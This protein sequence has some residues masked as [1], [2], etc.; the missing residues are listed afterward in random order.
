MP[1]QDDQRRSLPSTAQSSLESPYLEEGF[2]EEDIEA[3]WKPRL[4]VLETESPF[5]QT[6]GLNHEKISHWETE[7]SSEL[8]EELNAHTAG[9][10][11]ELYEWD[12]FREHALEGKNDGKIDNLDELKDWKD[13]YNHIIQ[14]QE[15]EDGPGCTQIASRKC[16]YYTE[17]RNRWIDFFFP[18]IE[19][20]RQLIGRHNA[21]QRRELEKILYEFD[22]YNRK[23]IMP[24]VIE[25]KNLWLEANFKAIAEQHR[26]K[27]FGTLEDILAARHLDEVQRSTEQRV[28]R[29]VPNGVL[30]KEDVALAVVLRKGIHLLIGK[31][32][33]EIP[34]QALL[35][36]QRYLEKL[37][38]MLKKETEKPGIFQ[39]IWNVVG[40]NSWEDFVADMALTIATGGVLKGVRYLKRARKGIRIYRSAKKASL[41]AREIEMTLKQLD[42]LEKNLRR[43]IASRFLKLSKEAIEKTLKLVKKFLADVDFK[44]FNDVL[45]KKEKRQKIQDSVVASLLGKKVAGS[46]P[47][48]IRELIRRIDKEVVATFI[49]NVYGITEMHDKAAFYTFIKKRSFHTAMR[50]FKLN[51][52]RRLTVNYIYIF[53]RDLG[54]FDLSSVTEIITSTAA[55]VSND[56]VNHF[57][58]PR[59]IRALVE[60]VRRGVHEWVINMLK[61]LLQSHQKEIQKNQSEEIE[62]FLKEIIDEKQQETDYYKYEN[63]YYDKEL[64]NGELEIF[65]EF[66]DEE[67]EEFLAELFDAEFDDEN[68]DEKEGLD[69]YYLDDEWYDEHVDREL[70]EKPIIQTVGMSAKKELEACNK[71]EEKEKVIIK[72]GKTATLAQQQ[73]EEEVKPPADLTRF[74]RRVLNATE[75]E[76]LDDNGDLGPLTRG[77][78]IA[79][80]SGH[81]V[82]RDATIDATTRNALTSAIARNTH[83]TTEQERQA[84]SPYINEEFFA[85]WEVETEKPWN[86]IEIKSRKPGKFDDE[87][88]EEWVDEAL[89]EESD[90]ERT[91]EV[92]W[93]EWEEEVDFDEDEFSDDREEMGSESDLELED[94]TGVIGVDDRKRVKNSNRAPYRW[95]CHL[96]G[97]LEVN[98]ARSNQRATGTGVL[99]SPRHVL[100]AAHIIYHSRKDNRGLWR[101]TRVNAGSILVS[102]GRLS[103]DDR[104]FGRVGVKAV[105]VHPNWNPRTHAGRQYDIAILTL[106]KDI[107]NETFKLLGNRPL[108]FFDR[109]YAVLERI[110][111]K[112]LRSSDVCTAGYPESLGRGFR[113]YATK[114]KVIAASASSRLLVT[115]ADATPGQSGSPLWIKQNSQLVLV[116]ILIEKGKVVNTAVRITRELEGVI[117]AWLAHGGKE[118]EFEETFVDDFLEDEDEYDWEDEL[119]EAEPEPSEELEVA[120]DREMEDTE[121]DSEYI[122]DLGAPED[123]DPHKKPEELGRTDL[124]KEFRG[125][126]GE[127][128]KTLIREIAMKLDLDPGLLAAI[129]FAEKHSK[130]PLLSIKGNGLSLEGHAGADDWFI[131]YRR[132]LIERVLKDYGEDFSYNDKK[133]TF[134]YGDVKKTGQRWRNELGVWKERGRMPKI[135]SVTGVGHI[136]SVVIVVAIY[137][138][139]CE[140]YLKDVLRDIQ[141][142]SVK[143]HAYTAKSFRKQGKLRRYLTREQVKAFQF[144]T[145]D[146]LPAEYRFVLL[147]VAYNRGL[148]GATDLLFKLGKGGD[149]KRR[150]GTQRNPKDAE[151]T[152]VLH[153]ARAIHLSQAV[154]GTSGFVLEF[155]HFLEKGK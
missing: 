17:E 68:R 129:V 81:G 128:L 46:D 67:Q 118:K 66:E 97:R 105:T 30:V 112:T 2:L 95:V 109:P 114:G 149:I 137:L 111:I 146:E 136:S 110:P 54:R 4:E 20:A 62:R 85:D 125:R 138:K 106:K 141:K 84:S 8:N 80:K 113:M 34:R 49:E 25:A 107:G 145:F 126:S 65:N 39:Q 101:D 133:V 100:T 51:I 135:P 147:R 83:E 103:K 79:F 31:I 14:I 142:S 44:E 48:V 45:F 127:E 98:G 37:Q 58:V 93:E 132:R 124:D 28:E 150:G 6:F 151:R 130:T 40:W 123:G 29:I 72:S 102:P 42:K 18:R 134:K 9:I 77:A 15:I 33:A 35:R 24:A 88:D 38:E 53:L 90:D 104:P 92:N 140:M 96:S 120:D 59:S 19:K 7:G 131:P 75:G 60:S 36:Q 154:F 61:Q 11:E 26:L 94:E 117:R 10:D 22:K 152:A 89:E 64:Y 99:I 119:V 71:I 122:P 108:G 5:L 74:A 143:E 1:S 139:S 52:R 115:S 63:E 32:R 56:L 47:S 69:N 57:V 87:L 55:E 3:E 50:Y 148:G 73:I 12:S 116:G 153:V 76:R 86:F 70:D 41:M 78:L 16:T 121:V 27:N 91:E 21:D 23:K 43:R 13:F 82:G 155:G 144:R